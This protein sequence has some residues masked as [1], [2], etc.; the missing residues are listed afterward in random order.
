[1]ILAVAVPSVTVTVYA[2]SPPLVAGSFAIQVPG[3]PPG[4]AGITAVALLGDASETETFAGE[5]RG[6]GLKRAS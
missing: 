2:V 3:G 5:W 4:P 6:A 1:M